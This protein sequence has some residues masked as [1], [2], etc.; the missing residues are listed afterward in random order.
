M[1]AEKRK[2]KLDFKMCWGHS[3]SQNRDPE[4]ENC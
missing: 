4:N 1:S 2:K 3:S